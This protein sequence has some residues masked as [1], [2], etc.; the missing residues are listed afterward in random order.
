MNLPREEYSTR[1]SLTIVSTSLLLGGVILAAA[2]YFHGVPENPPGFYIDESS[3]AYNAYTI[4]QTGHDEHGEA[5]PLYFRAFGEYKNPTYIYFLAAL[6]RLF[7][8]SI[9][10]ARLLSAALGIAA[11]ALLWLLAVRL[12]GRRPVGHVIALSALLTPWLFENSRPV[13]EVALYPALVALFLLAL[14]RASK[15]HWGLV[16]ALSLVATLA[17]LTYSSSI[18]RLLGPML[19]AGLALFLTRQRLR[20]VITTWLGYALT[21]VPLLVFNWRHPG[22]LM[23][24]FWLLTYIEPE[25]STSAIALEFITRYLVN[26]SPWR[27]AVTG[28]VNIRDHI[29]TMGSILAPTIALAALGLVVLLRYCRRDAWWRFIIYA[30]AV[31]VVPASLTTTEFPQ[32]RLIAFPVIL[33]VLAIPAVTWLL[34]GA[35]TFASGQRAPEAAPLPDAPSRWL[36]GSRRAVLVLLLV[37]LLIQGVVFR[38]QYHRAGPLRGYVF[39]EQFP[40]EVFPAALALNKEQIYLYDPLGKSGYIQ[41]YWYGMLRGMNALQFVRMAPDAVLPPGAVVI[42]TEEKCANCRL[43]LKSINYIVYVAGTDAGR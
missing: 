11:A 20:G 26:I 10:L 19:A 6:F 21:L 14:Q 39:D 5:W 18:G 40:R 36:I 23:G 8:P 32:I 17:L 25:R 43:V 4:S 24:R 13:F 30:L 2:S 29:G 27:L 16:D 38:W 42:S 28:E 31:S 1:R 9:L 15:K 35:E 37:L 34:Y 12:T 3:I 22:A 7:G 33:H 41:G